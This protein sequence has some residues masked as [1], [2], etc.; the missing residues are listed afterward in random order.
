[1]A[2]VYDRNRREEVLD[3]IRGFE[4]DAGNAPKILERHGVSQGECEQVFFNRPLLGSDIEHSTVESRFFALGETDAGRRMMIVFT[5]REDRIRI[6]SARPM[7][8][9]EG[10]EYVKAQRTR[11]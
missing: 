8:R 5:V 1:M 7:S 10:R 4:W 6:I 3:G 9:K 11:G 2:D